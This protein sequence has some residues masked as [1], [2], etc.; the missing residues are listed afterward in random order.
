MAK[1]WTSPNTNA[2]LSEWP[3]TICIYWI[4]IRGLVK[5]QNEA[6]LV[7]SKKHLVSSHENMRCRYSEAPERRTSNECPQHVFLWRDGENNHQRLLLNKSSGCLCK[8]KKVSKYIRQQMHRSACASSQSDPC[9]LTDSLISE[10]HQQS[11]N[12][13]L[14]TSKNNINLCI[15]HI[16]RK[17]AF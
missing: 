2:V 16:V 5:K 14:S 1:K 11:P 17:C 13:S 6:Y 4:V 8:V 15:W 10:D 12:D 3:H 7:G 9:P